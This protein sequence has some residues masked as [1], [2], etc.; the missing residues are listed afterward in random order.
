MRS[1]RCRGSEGDRN[2]MPFQVS[3]LENAAAELV[4]RMER[5]RLLLR[6]GVQ[7]LHR[8]YATPDLA[9]LSSLSVSD[10]EV[11]LLL[12][13]EADAVF[14]TDWDLTL[15]RYTQTLE[16]RYLLTPDAATLPFFSLQ[17]RFALDPCEVDFCV[18]LLAYELDAAYGRVYAYLH[19]D[20][21]R[22][23]PSVSLAL[24]VLA[25]SWTDRLRLRT[26]LDDRSALFRNGL[27][28]ADGGGAPVSP[29][30]G[31]RL[32]TAVV[33]YLLGQ[34]LVP[35]FV[36]LIA[37]SCGLESMHL[38]PQVREQLPRLLM[39]VSSHITMQSGTFGVCIS[40]PSGSGKTTLAAALAG[41][42][43][44]RLAMC[45]PMRATVELESAVHLR[46]SL[47]D[48]QLA[49][50]WPCFDVRQLSVEEQERWA[51]RLRSNWLPP[52]PPI[53]FVLTTAE[54]RAEFPLPG[55]SRV[56]LF[57]SPLPQSERQ[58]LFTQALTDNEQSYTA[59]DL[60][61]L[62][63]D[64]P[65]PPGS[66]LRAAQVAAQ[67]QHRGKSNAETRLTLLRQELRASLPQ[68]LAGLAEKFPQLHDWDD[69]VLS[70][71]ALQQLRE[72]VNAVSNRE[73]VL[74]RWG[75]GRK[76]AASG[77]LRALFHGPPGTGKTLAASI[78]SRALGIPLYR[79]DLS[80]IVSKYIGETEKNLER[81]FT[82][83][84]QLGCVLLFDE[85]DALFGKRTDVKDAHD[86]YSN[87]Q[88]AYLLQR[89][90]TYS[91]ISLLATNYRNNIDAAFYR[92]IEYIIEFQA[93][94]FSQRL[95]LWQ[96]HLPESAR[97]AELDRQFLENI[98]LQFE[99]PGGYIRN[100]ALRA[101]YLAAADDCLI[102]RRHVLF[103]IIRESQKLGR[104]IVSAEFGIY[105]T[106][107][108]EATEPAP[109]RS[110]AS[111]A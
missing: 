42:L 60:V 68:T 33:H 66:I 52:G 67:L 15:S 5:L 12:D 35:D 21:T 107:I 98:A 23:R 43:G 19:N 30:D 70:P 44:G 65:L 59:A 80:R 71:D 57:L 51:A 41:A 97:E 88:V 69:L 6:R 8:F 4:A 14:T 91:G 58:T 101:A 73:Q 53:F 50:A 39:Q 26:I 96:M 49:Q 37:E 85:A 99:F 100:M 109:N 31:L 25:E 82:E 13:R 27:V 29:A 3:P 45:P 86:R 22:P 79:I 28:L 83:A 93:P 111:H 72:L 9:G 32:D 7:R 62:A 76:I 55:E 47:R 2:T 102:C 24:D 46:R 95:R 87:I 103:G 84:E 64:F 54:L 108:D 89:L 10:R 11:E 40:G 104:T 94:N 74:A 90:E 36:E 106:Y 48:M 63:N 78:V 20:V 1:L 56:S 77:G 61:G 105:A 110:Q 38:A 16:Q 92:R 81:I 18:L 17:R 75:F 34:S